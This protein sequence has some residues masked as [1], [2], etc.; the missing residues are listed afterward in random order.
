MKWHLPFVNTPTDLGLLKR[1]YPRPQLVRVKARKQAIIGKI[2]KSG[3]DLWVDCGV[4]GL[5]RREKATPEWHK[6]IAGLF[7]EWAAVLDSTA[8]S[9][10]PSAFTSS[11]LEVAAAYHPKWLSIPQVP[12]VDDG[13]RNNLNRLLAKAT[14]SWADKNQFDGKLILPVILTHRNQTRDRTSRR[15]KIDAVKSILSKCPA[16]GIW[17]VDSNLDDHKVSG[18]S[19]KY[20]RQLIDFHTELNTTAQ[21]EPLNKIVGPYWGPKSCTLGTE[22]V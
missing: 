1:F 6:W 12:H 20:L 10:L 3:L 19:Q 17:V 13:S 15:K 8:S 21:I 11:V 7:P 4:D 22:T 5:H 16:Y 14:R 18:T 9:P 2:Q